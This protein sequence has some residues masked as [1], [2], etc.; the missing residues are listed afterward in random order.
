MEIDTELLIKGLVM[1]GLMNLKKIFEGD[2]KY[3]SGGV[4]GRHIKLPE[5]LGFGPRYSESMQ[6]NAKADFQYWDEAFCILEDLGIEL[7]EEKEYFERIR[8]VDANRWT[9]PS[10]G[11]KD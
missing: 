9:F 7:D 1:T 4:R 6:E 3:S 2:H 10:S 11:G 8:K 5:Y